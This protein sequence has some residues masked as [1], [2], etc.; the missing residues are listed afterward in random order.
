MSKE[1]KKSKK[2][3]REEAENM[4]EKATSRLANIK[5]RIQVQEAIR[6][7]VLAGFTPTDKYLENA[8]FMYQKSEEYIEANRQ[9]KVL[10]YQD[11]I[12]EL[13]DKKKTLEDYI[14]ELKQ[15]IKENRG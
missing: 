6:D 2:E 15:T 12:E 7:S 3:L 4:L 11:A 5:Q 1:D 14:P 10:A 9:A 13:E 8:D